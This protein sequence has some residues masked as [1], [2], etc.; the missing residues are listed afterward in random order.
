MNCYSKRKEWGD[1][2]EILDQ[3]MEPIRADP[4]PAVPSLVPGT[5]PLEGLHGPTLLLCFL[6]H[7]T[8]SWAGSTLCTQL[9][10]T[11]VLE[12]WHLQH[13]VVSTSLQVPPFLLHI[14]VSQAL[15]LALPLC[16]P[17]VVLEL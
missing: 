1:S 10:L 4:N 15:L 8:L 5:S 16:L 11:E 2:E 12:L 9:L 13:I 3:I 6:H 7:T 17:S 14:T